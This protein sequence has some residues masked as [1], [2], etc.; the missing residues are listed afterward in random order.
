MLNPVIAGASLLLIL[1]SSACGDDE[2]GSNDTSG[3]DTS[4][5]ADTS[6]GET[7]APADTSGGE[8]TAPAD[9]IEA[10]DT[11]QDTAGGDTSMPPLGPCEQACVEAHPVGVPLL[12]QWFGCQEAACAAFEPG[13]PEFDGCN[14]MSWTPDNPDAACQAETQ[15]CFSN[16][17]AGCKELVDLAAVACEPE[18]L[19]MSEQE[20]G[21]A[22]LCMIELGWNA[23]PAVQALAWPLYTCVFFAEGEAG[24]A[25][26]CL[27]GADAC[28]ECAA[29][30]CQAPYDA[31]IANSSGA[32]I[33]PA[34]VPAD[35]ADCRGAF[36]CMMSC[37]P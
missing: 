4:Q 37:M 2:S 7:T 33:T 10:P 25:S 28:R 13:T 20:L 35:A 36:R 17:D 3:G 30:K 18:T 1:A 14:M 26:E 34:E 9:T 6:G 22:G 27:G 31:C 23:T 21:M 5:P 15:K 24:C 19:P 12:M 29:S 32:A 8:T 16:T 11:A